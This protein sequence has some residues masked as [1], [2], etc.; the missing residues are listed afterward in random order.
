MLKQRFRILNGKLDMW[1]NASVSQLYSDWVN[2]WRKEYGSGPVKIRDTLEME[3]GGVEDE[4]F[5]F[6]LNLGVNIHF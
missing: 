5:L 1:G 4:S 6:F 2:K 3:N